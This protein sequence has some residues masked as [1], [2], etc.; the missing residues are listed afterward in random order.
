MAEGE[1]NW[2]DFLV[3]LVP[4]G[5][6]LIWAA[7]AATVLWLLR[8]PISGVFMSLADR[9]RRGDDVESPWLSVKRQRELDSLPEAPPGSAQPM[10]EISADEESNGHQLARDALPSSVKEW[11]AYR[12]QIYGQARDL[13]L[14]HILKPSK[15]N[16]QEYD[17]FILVQRHKKSKGLGDVVGAEFYLGRSWGH[18]IFGEQPSNNVAGLKTSAFGPFLCVCKVTFTDGYQAMLERYIDFEMGPAAKKA[19]GK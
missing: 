13:Y 19:G 18:R 7:L 11:N 5:Q 9:V 2:I 3:S 4:L 17:I 12:G 10:P 8:S 6:T 16:G 14:A 1:T 15:T